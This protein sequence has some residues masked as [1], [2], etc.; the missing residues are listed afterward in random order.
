MKK[1]PSLF[2]VLTLLAA[3]FGGAAFLLLIGPGFLRTVPNNGNPFTET[4]MAYDFI[5]GNKTQALT[6]NGY[7]AL[8]AAFVMLV[9]AFAFILLALLM[10]FSSG[11]KFAGF[12][13]FVAGLLAIAS[14]VIFLLAK[15]IVNADA[16][17]A[18]QWGFLGAAVASLATGLLAGVSGIVGLKSKE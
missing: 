15:N 10:G 14:G 7:G 12:L 5:F 11:I 13:A 9:V 6:N 3:V 8:I 16:S 18:I 2:V 17:Y 1:N 4:L